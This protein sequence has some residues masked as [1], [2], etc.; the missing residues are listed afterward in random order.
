MSISE[1]TPRYKCPQLTRDQDKKEIT[2]EKSSNINRNILLGKMSYDIPFMEARNFKQKYETDKL[3]NEK[4]IIIARKFEDLE[5]SE[6]WT[7]IADAKMH[8]DIKFGDL[9]IS[10]HNMMS[11]YN[12]IIK[13]LGYSYTDEYMLTTIKVNDERFSKKRQEI[14]SRVADEKMTCYGTRESQ[15]FLVYIPPRIRKI[16]DT[17]K[18]VKESNEK[19][20][21]NRLRIKMENKLIIRHMFEDQM[22]EKLTEK[23]SR[24]IERMKTQLEEKNKIL[25]TG[26]IV[27]NI[28][29][30]IMTA[31][32]LFNTFRH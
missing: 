15:D 7:I 2:E 10:R 23:V 22:V 32:A 20:Y 25:S 24:N 9:F 30:V 14:M 18:E 16:Y 12:N 5:I 13:S 21:D 29:F 28:N 1:K 17:P 26:V 6:M 31:C 27:T 3:E 19:K 11:E 8:L 4:L